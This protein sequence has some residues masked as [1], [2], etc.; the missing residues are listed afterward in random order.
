MA[1]KAE[2]EGKVVAYKGG[3][4]KRDAISRAG[5]RNYLNLEDKNVP[6]FDHII[7]TSPHYNEYLKDY[8]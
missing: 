3:I 2:A 7:P 6:K 1:G 5:F 8:S 4:H